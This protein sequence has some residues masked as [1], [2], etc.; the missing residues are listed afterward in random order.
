MI[1]KVLYYFIRN[2]ETLPMKFYFLNFKIMKDILQN[3][4]W[5]LV[6]GLSSFITLII[7]WSIYALAKD[8][9]TEPQS[10]EANP[11]TT[12][13]SNSWNAILSNQ[14]ILSGSINNLPWTHYSTGEIFSGNFW[15]NGEKIYMRTINF[16]K[17]P[18]GSSGR[19][20]KN[21]GIDYIPNI[22]DLVDYKWFYTTAAGTKVVLPYSSPLAGSILVVW[23]LDENFPGLSLVSEWIDMTIYSDVYVTIYYTKQQK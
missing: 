21:L 17:W 13:N 22:K 14:N 4:K 15:V 10:L 20:V 2:I 6:I 11:W 3:I 23:Y 7:A 18:N 8:V 16:G 5:W 12:L 9:W 1:V 19:A